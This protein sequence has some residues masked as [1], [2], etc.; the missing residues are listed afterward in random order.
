MIGFLAMQISV[1]VH[2][3]IAV[4]VYHIEY[5]CVWFRHLSARNPQIMAE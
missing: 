2:Q 3:F 5:A 4:N 1:V